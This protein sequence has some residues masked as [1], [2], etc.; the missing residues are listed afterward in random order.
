M[1]IPKTKAIVLETGKSYH[2]YIPNGQGLKK[3]HIDAVLKNKAYS[4]R[5]E[6]IDNAEDMIVYRFWSK[7]KFRWY[8]EVKSYWEIC[9]FN[10]WEYN[11]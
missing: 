10:D 5:P 2:I 8:W 1:K 11:K 7:T 3:V 6:M 9:L 4:P